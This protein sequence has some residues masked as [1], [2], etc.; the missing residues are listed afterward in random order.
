MEPFWITGR[1]CCIPPDTYL[2]DLLHEG[3]KITCTETMRCRTENT[4]AIIYACNNYEYTIAVLVSNNY[5]DIAALP[6]I[7]IETM[8]KFL[9]DDIGEPLECTRNT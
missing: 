8:R 6:K 5:T 1:E 2:P 7:D 4:L 9:E 3:I